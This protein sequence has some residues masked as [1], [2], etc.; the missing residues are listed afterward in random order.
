MDNASEAILSLKPVTFRYRK[1]L[2]PEGLPEFGLVAD[3][4]EKLNPDVV[5]ATGNHDDRAKRSLH[6]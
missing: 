3:G 2:G 4:V 5:R 1:E 6:G